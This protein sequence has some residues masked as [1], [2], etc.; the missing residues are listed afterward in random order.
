M[1][2]TFARIN[3]VLV[4]PLTA[5]VNSLYL[6]SSLQ[7]GST[8]ASAVVPVT[9]STAAYGQ[10]YRGMPVLINTAT[11]QLVPANASTVASMTVAYAGVLVD[12]VTQFSLARGTKVSYIFRGRVRSYAG[13]A[14]TVGDYVKVD[15]STNFS[16]FLKWVDGTDDP[17]LRVGQYM[18]IDDGSAE[19]GSSAGTSNVQGDAIFVNLF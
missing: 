8:N 15:T 14:L 1:G 6:D 13:G 16:G 9:G 2:S 17:N 10:M 12:D 5:Q 7:A 3:G 19:N 11:G 4:D 18:P